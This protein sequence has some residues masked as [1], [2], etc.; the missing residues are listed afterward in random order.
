MISLLGG[1]CTI[2][3]ASSTRRR[4]LLSISLLAAL[5]AMTPLEFIPETCTPLTFT[6]APL[7]CTPDMRSVSVT[8]CIIA[9]TTSSICTIEPFR[10]PW[11][12]AEP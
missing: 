8:A 7:T 3:A 11:F 12:S 6:V 4:S 2:V 10:I 1:N 9:S 5:I